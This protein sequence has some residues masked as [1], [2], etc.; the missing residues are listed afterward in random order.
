MYNL[1]LILASR[2]IW[3]QPEAFFFLTTKTFFHLQLFITCR[4]KMFST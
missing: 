2:R 3:D 1:L 4:D